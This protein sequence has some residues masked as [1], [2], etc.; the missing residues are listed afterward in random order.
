MSPSRHRPSSC[1]LP[2]LASL[3]LVAAEPCF[4]QGRL[5]TDSEAMV[6]WLRAVNQ[7]EPGLH[8]EAVDSLAGRTL[9]ELK[10]VLWA[11]GELRK[12]LKGINAN[13]R[14]RLARVTYTE[15][16]MAALLGLTVQEVRRGEFERL[17]DRAAVAHADVAMLAPPAPSTATATA[18][19]PAVVRLQDG[20]QQEVGVG[21]I[22]WD[23]ARRA[24]ALIGPAASTHSFVRTW[25][26]ATTAVLEDRRFLTEVAAHLAWARVVLPNDPDVEFHSGC[27][28]ETLASDGVQATIKAIQWPIRRNAR[29]VPDDDSIT[30]SAP[31]L[32]RSA[33]AFFRRTL[34][35]KPDYLEAH[36]RLGRLLG[37][38]GQH[39]EAAREL[40]TVLAGHPPE[41]GEYTAHLF[42]G[43]EEEQLGHLDVARAEFAQAARLFPNAQAPHLALALLERRAGN[44]RAAM[45]ATERALDAAANPIER[46]DPWHDFYLLQGQDAEKLVQTMYAE[47]KAGA[48]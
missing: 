46:F 48:R 12:D 45:A 28:D 17:I 19:A 26:L 23:I 10:S 30:L 20:Q 34:E 32:K 7:H 5:P 40:Q 31:K 43:D 22:H 18:S 41:G 25:Y 8:D 1:L 36:L 47:L 16:Q 42:L 29:M 13:T 3:L 15:G 38:L 24:I 14:I 11:L 39:E 44:R 21:S 35:L 27:I 4:A 9:G 2:L 37:D 6:S 33:I